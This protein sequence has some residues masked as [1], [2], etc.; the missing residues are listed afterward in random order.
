M[1][2]PP[3]GSDRLRDD[4][5]FD[6]VLTATPDAAP[7]LLIDTAVAAFLD[8]P[9]YQWLQPDP[10]ARE[11]LLRANFQLTLA[12]G[13]RNAELWST[14]HGAAVAVWS[15]PGG[16]LLGADDEAEFADVLGRHVGSRAAEAGA[17]MSACAALEPD[18]PHATLHIL[19]AHPRRQRRGLGAGLLAQLLER[20]DAAGIGV[21]LESSNVANV[22]FYERF[23][24][25]STGRVRLP[26][27]PVITTMLRPAGSV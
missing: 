15:M 19:A 26:E 12:A 14:D 7:N 5:S 1:S 23:G 6:S 2:E 20:C 9:L 24:F 3:P 16:S 13:A 10:S 25:G 27:G 21:W 22:G 18:G 8:D 17:S 11:R 4:R